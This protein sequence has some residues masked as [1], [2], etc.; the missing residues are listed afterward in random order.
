MGQE[1]KD[2][3]FR[4]QDALNA[5]FDN[6]KE[7]SLKWNAQG[8]GTYARY[9]ST[10]RA[11]LQLDSMMD[12]GIVHFTGPVNPSLEE[13]LSLYIQPPTAKPWGY[14]G[15]PGHPFQDEWWDVCERTLWKGVRSLNS[16]KESFDERLLEAFVQYSHHLAHFYRNVVWAKFKL[17]TSLELRAQ[18]SCLWIFPIQRQIHLLHRRTIHDSEPKDIS[19]PYT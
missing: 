16:R 8:L 6:W 13:V 7:L 4:D 2:S 9:P 3:K 10:E 12:P 1:M 5:I 14:L 17:Y 18:E 11:L 15:A 19:F